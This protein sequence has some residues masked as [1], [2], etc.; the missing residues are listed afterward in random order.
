MGCEQFEE[1][2]RKEIEK[3]IECLSEKNPCL[4]E[5]MG[6]ERKDENSERE[7]SMNE[8]KME[9][10]KHTCERDLESS[11]LDKS[12]LVL[13]NFTESLVSHIS[14]HEIPNVF[15]ITFPGF[16]DS[17]V[18]YG[19]INMDEKEERQIA[20]FGQDDETMVGKIELAHMRDKATI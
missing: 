2:E 12:A 13:L 7:E 16:V 4:I 15:I 14:N 5:S 19:G 3:E 11:S 17:S 9:F 18:N 6:F 1:Y 20:H 10:N 8:K